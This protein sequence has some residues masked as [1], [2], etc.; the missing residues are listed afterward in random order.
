[1]DTRTGEIKHFTDDEF[2]NLPEMEKKNLVFLTPEL[3]K[4]LLGMSR[5]Q[6]RAYYKKNRKV[7]KWPSWAEINSEI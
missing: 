1:M 3:H 4:M 5:E 2:R 7:L 6:R